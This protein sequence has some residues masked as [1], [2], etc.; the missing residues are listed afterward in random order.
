MA[1]AA[2]ATAH[3]STGRRWNFR[4]VPVLHDQTIEIP[5]G[6]AA[7]APLRP[8]LVVVVREA[9]RRRQRVRLEVAL[10]AARQWE[11]VYRV[12]RRRSPHDR[13]A[14]QL[15]QR[16]HLIGPPDP[17]HS[18]PVQRHPRQFT[19]RFADVEVAQRRD[20]EAG[21]V[22][23]HRVGLGGLRGHLPLEFEVQTISHEHFWHSGRVFLDFL[24]PPVDAVE[25]PLVRDV[26]DQDNALRTPRIRSNDCAEPSLAG[27]VPELQFH[28]FSVQED[29]CGLVR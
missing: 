13:P 20:L 24:Q 25:A 15:L 11:R 1:A 26:I 2:P 22:V 16:Q 5:Y 21:H 28:A 7:P 18:V 17:L 9:L 23:S 29:R 3:H 4:P 6:P 12:H 27:S 10:H 19:E 14:A 8:V